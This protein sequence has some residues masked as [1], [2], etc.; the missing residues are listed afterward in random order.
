MIRRFFEFLLSLHQVHLTPST[1]FSFV[2]D[3][4][5]LIALG[6]LGLG[7]LGFL[8][9]RHQAA[10]PAKKIGMGIVRGVLL[11]LVFVLVWRPEIV[12][13]HEEHERSVIAVWVD[14]SASMSLEDPYK[15]QGMR[16]F[17]RAATL[18]TPVP[19][20]QTR[21][22]RYQ[23]A[24]AALD[25]A[26]WLK[27]LT[28]TQDVAI[29]TGGS[30]AQLLGVAHTAEQLGLLLEPMKQTIP[31]GESTNVPAVVQEILQ[32][33]QGQ[34]VSAILLLTD[35][36]T[37][38]AG[39][40]LDGAL[41][42][43]ERSGAKLFP[44][45]VGQADEP[46]DLKIE[47]VQLPENA[48]VRDPIAV[49]VRV[50]GTGITAGTPAKVT[51]YR[52]EGTALSVL[53]S[54]EFSLDPSKKQMDVELMFKPETIKGEKEETYDLVARVEPLSDAAGE[55]LTKSNND[56]SA[57]THV[58]DAQI[59]ALYVDGYPRWEFR[60]LKNELIR[61]KTVNVSSLLLSA[62]DDFS[63][64]ADPAIEKDGRLIFPGPITR[65][66]ETAEELSKYDILYIGDVDPTY[67][68]PT[69]QK[70]II[71]FVGNGGG[72]CWIAGTMYNPEAYRDT[73]LSVLLPIIPDELDPRARV[74]APADNYAFNLVLTAAGRDSNL[75]RFFDD[76]EL[77]VKQM[78]ELPEMYW[79]KPVLGAAP[80]A[81]VL[82]VHPTRTQGGNPMPL[83]VTGHYKRGR[84]VFSGVADTWRWRRYNGEPLFQSYWLQMSRLLY[85]NKALGQSKQVELA[86]ESS[87]VEVGNSLKAT[88]DVKDPTLLAQMPAQIPVLLMDK[89]TPGGGPLGTLTLVRTGTSPAH[90]EG[91]LTATQVG[92]YQLLIPPG[93]LPSE[94]GE[95]PPVGVVVERPQREFQNIGTDEV[96]L[97][98]LANKTTGAVIPLDD[99]SQLAKKIPDRSMPV[100]ISTSE[101]LWYKPFALALVVA[102]ATIEWL[103]RKSA[104]LI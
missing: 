64:D 38:E 84:T 32:N 4:P 74:M 17:R 99:A 55:E 12:V 43:A 56:A 77:N 102:L 16:D 25:D 90:F 18:H 70:L 78:A 20:G 7:V 101:E 48:F 57:I 45:P 39:A 44:L 28:Q 36:Q 35:G 60:Y 13:E 47:S 42:S 103:L 95:V 6:A 37:T 87:D 5:A 21:L 34:R 68:S 76:P 24:I 53:A 93:V 72:I 1:H 19:R 83:I 40:R 81:E 96:S 65:F 52:K 50:E 85:R 75:F 3:Y 62:D 49:K 91:S 11:M 97:A 98:T 14:N 8:S 89:K 82:A 51:L 92:D 66:P 33:S 88:L 27:G 80:A 69:Q 100:L 31:A 67:F 26:P 30:H 22:N 79:Y 63:Q 58:L 23:L 9:Y 94:A 46:F 2:W 59:N 29:Y 15:D 61:E 86:A 73:P 104:G 10:S 41:A 54:K 71:D